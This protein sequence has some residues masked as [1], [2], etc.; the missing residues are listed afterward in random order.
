MQRAE[1]RDPRHHLT[2]A[3]LKAMGITDD[4][5]KEPERDCKGSLF[6][7]IAHAQI[8]IKYGQLTCI[9]NFEIGA[10]RYV[11]E[12]CLR[13]DFSIILPSKGNAARRGG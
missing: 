8:P 1:N 11:Y 7:P 4:I 2:S 12:Y 3:P 9:R 6:A 13:I 10:R 5:N